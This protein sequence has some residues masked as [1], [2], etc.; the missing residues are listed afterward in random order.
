MPNSNELM[1]GAISSPTLRENGCAL[2]FGSGLCR[3]KQT[4][5]PKLSRSL[6]VILHSFRRLGKN[7]S[8]G[9][10]DGSDIEA[11]EIECQGHAMRSTHAMTGKRIIDQEPFDVEP[12]TGSPRYRPSRDDT[13]T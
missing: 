1:S 6:G 11:G 5:E 8:Q 7:P 10:A 12:N 9:P 2:L 13:E 3:S 4:G